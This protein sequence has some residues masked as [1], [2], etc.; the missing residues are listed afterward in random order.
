[1]DPKAGSHAWQAGPAVAAKY[2]GIPH[3]MIAF[4]YQNPIS[5]AYTN[6]SASPKSE[7]EFQ[8]LISYTLGHG[9]Y[10]K[11]ADSTWTVNWRRHA[12]T[13]IPIGRGSGKVWKFSGPELNTWVSGEWTAYRQF[14][15]ITPMYTIKFGLTLLFPNVEL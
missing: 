14:A 9:M 3:L 13:I 11:S 6:K 10:V 12:S 2:V 1:R 15:G 5:F 8:P 4:L 7:M